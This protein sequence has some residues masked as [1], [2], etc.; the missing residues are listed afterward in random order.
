MRAFSTLHRSAE[1]GLP[2]AAWEI[3]ECLRKGVGV[4]C[5]PARSLVWYR[6]AAD[7]DF[8]EA[9]LQ[10][11]RA[12]RDGAGVEVH[13]GQA[14]SSLTLAADDGSDPNAQYELGLMLLEGLGTPV[15]REE[16]LGWLQAAA[17]QG[18]A[19]SH[20]KIAEL[21]RGPTRSRERFVVIDFATTGLS[22]P[23][24]D[25]V[26]EVGAVESLDGSIGRCFQSL[27]NP[28]FPVTARITEITGIT[29]AILAEAPPLA[30][31][32][33]EVA[34]FIEGANLIAHNASFDRRFLQAELERLALWNDWE[35]LC[36]MQL[37]KRAYPGL[38]SYKLAALV[39]HAGVVLPDALHR[40]LADA[41]V[42]AELFL[43][44]RDQSAENST[45]PDSSN[46]SEFFSD[47]SIGPAN[48][49]PGPQSQQTS[50]WRRW[51]P[52]FS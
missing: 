34:A 10:L 6:R 41:M 33:R 14:P 50:S 16:A 48:A 29:N 49:A 4:A 5:D 15:D 18:H 43:I 2:P 39:S 3:A 11:G 36:T 51:F 7:N 24:G 1:A 23:K 44:I 45:E 28:G 31:V 19:S 22:P 20:A 26:I 27:A 25:R 37:G 47:L 52:A 21:N 40:A 30:E 13:L 38:G 17:D 9:K 42:T 8:A 35:M 12:Y 46:V 32:M